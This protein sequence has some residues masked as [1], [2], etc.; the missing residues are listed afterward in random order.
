MELVAGGKVDEARAAIK[1][2]E[3]DR[4]P[5]FRASC[6]LLKGI[7]ALKS[8]QSP[9]GD[10][11][12]AL[13]LFREGGD[14]WGQAE[15][16]M[17]LGTFLREKGGPGS[18]RAESYL[19]ESVS[20]FEKEGDY[21]KAGVSSVGLFL[22]CCPGQD[23]ATVD[24]RA[25]AAV[26]YFR[27]AGDSVREGALYSQWSGYYYQKGLY[28]KSLPL[29]EKALQ[30]LEPSGNSSA[31]A[32]SYMQIANTLCT[33]AR[34]AEALPHL[35]SALKLDTDSRT[36][37]LIFSVK[38]DAL[39]SLGRV[40]EAC[41]ALE[42]SAAEYE[43]G[44]CP[45]ELA[46]VHYRMASILLETGDTQKAI[47]H[48]SSSLELN[49]ALK[50]S[51][52]ISDA[53]RLMGDIYFTMGDTK[54]GFEEYGRA[55]DLL[56]ESKNTGALARTLSYLGSQWYFLGDFAKAEA[57]FSESIAL[58]KETRDPQE[59][60]S[61]VYALNGLGN[62]Y[63]HMG[64]LKDAET[65]IDAAINISREAGYY[66]GELESL[67]VR[68]SFYRHSGQV[69]KEYETLE[70]ALSMAAQKNDLAQQALAHTSLGLCCEQ[71]GDVNEARS[72]YEASLALNE[73]MPFKKGMGAD[74]INLGFISCFYQGDFEAAEA[75][76]RKSLAIYREI[77]DY[78]GVIMSLKFLGG[79]YK[80]RGDRGRALQYYDEAIQMCEQRGYAGEEQ[81]IRYMVGLYT[82]T[83]GAVKDGLAMMEG[84]ADYYR[85][86]QMLQE[87]AETDLALARI[88]AFLTGDSEKAEKRASEA[89]ALFRKL[90]D[91]EGIFQCRLLQA[92]INL[93]KEL[94]DE[95]LREFYA[96]KEEAKAG[97]NTLARLQCLDEISTLYGEKLGDAEK[98]RSH[99]DEALTI[100]RDNGYIPG[101]LRYSMEMAKN[102]FLSSGEVEKSEKILED[103]A[104]RAE[105]IQ[106]SS[107]LVSLYFARATLAVQKKEYEKARIF[108]EEAAARATGNQELMEI[109]VG[110]MN[111]YGGMQKPDKVKEC[112]AQLNRLSENMTNIKQK[113]E[114]LSYLCYSCISRGDYKEALRLARERQE[115]DGRHHTETQQ[116]LDAF[117]TGRL[118][119][120]M[121]DYE[122]AL[123]FY[124]KAIELGDKIV[125][126]LKTEESLLQR[127]GV[128]LLRPGMLSGSLTPYGG[129]IKILLEKGQ[130]E[131]AFLYSE[132]DRARVF[133]A[134]IGTRAWPPIPKEQVNEKIVE[135]IRDLKSYSGL[136][137]V[138]TAN[139]GASTEISCG[140][141]QDTCNVRLV[142]GSAHDQSGRDE[143]A[144]SGRR[145]AA[146][147]F[148]E[149]L[150]PAFAAQYKKKYMEILPLLKMS[151]RDTYEL[152]TM[153]IR[154]PAE[155][156]ALLD[157]DTLLVEY[158][159]E[160]DCFFIFLITADGMDA[161]TC[162]VS[163]KDL[164]DKIKQFRN[165]IHNEASGSGI[166]EGL[167][168]V[169]RELY[170]I[171]VG[172]VESYVQSRKRIVIVPHRSLHYL[173][174]AAL[175]DERGRFLAETHSIAYLPSAST[176]AI[177]RAKLNS[178]KRDNEPPLAAFALGN[179]S[180]D[181]LSPL[182]AT[183]SEVEYIASLFQ[184]NVVRK[185]REFTRE[186]IA[187]LFPGAA[188]VHFATH[189][190][191]DNCYPYFSGIATSNGMFRIN[192][193]FTTIPAGN[194]CTLVTMSACNTALGRISTGDDLTGIS[195]AFMNRGIPT[196]VASLWSVS[197][198]STSKLMKYFYESLAS[199][200]DKD[201]A[202]QTAQARLMK[203]YPQPFHWASFITIGDWK[204]R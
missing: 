1:A 71:R 200:A 98:A 187:Q 201:E 148:F 194:S 85:E 141:N 94:I 184:K 130:K 101:E 14:R 104:Q 6:K 174:F 103:I 168:A 84:S 146:Q 48:I 139:S 56:R 119:E 137:Q 131:H 35:D 172:P 165:M 9:E 111:V 32:M 160:S 113:R 44:S 51:Q 68:S 62:L 15:T 115:F 177:C 112:L 183:S 144:F 136:L 132:K 202:L 197:D 38:G 89:S 117:E 23:D 151:A 180:A 17:R 100:C 164:N 127:T 166:S 176:L 204:T 47:S 92:R 76:Y 46:D 40:A 88:Y 36:R 27:R 186:S 110:L 109:T 43:K 25:A 193:I 129:A 55:I 22:L 30:I 128:S 79:L 124:E 108:L 4:D 24:L 161:R 191:L 185:E 192:D 171:L 16:L 156:K 175:I 91:A 19:E 29:A 33:I 63:G 52:G 142:P 162:Q 61:L 122:T 13:S 18:K 118:A 10:Y 152:K 155:L 199:G 154:T 53:R 5:L 90:N 133:L 39:H 80:N 150:T 26:E 121:E 107:F 8:D 20:L 116:F 140:E 83:G 65:L 190:V 7:I 2:R 198:E 149:N 97:G 179:I 86:H 59:L 57:H 12:Q 41:A 54:R 182:P 203:E 123:Q 60:V 126:R 106:D 135:N 138:L 93:E 3:E 49:S 178:E 21:R 99:L 31:L 69:N 189:G 169:S 11:E 170:E 66:E 87:C 37:G 159:V 34:P 73:A 67:N 158:Y 188:Y 70:K 173:P 105:K 167:S 82:F 78:H 45:A 50:N 120:S 145:E 58:L 75:H 181:G 153:S 134:N 72:H 64:R 102:Y 28:D 195:R 163:Q 157:E 114:I 143:M 147:D 96:L 196:V 74:H 81:H 95:A 77:R 125:G 42:S